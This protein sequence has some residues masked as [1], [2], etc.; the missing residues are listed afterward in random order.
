MAIVIA[1]F[2]LV[3][4][5][6]AWA[7]IAALSAHLAQ[8]QQ[9]LRQLEML[10]H[11]LAGARPARTQ[12]AAATDAAGLPPGAP[13]MPPPLPGMRGDA[14]MP[15]AAPVMPAPPARPP[16]TAVPVPPLPRQPEEPGVL[17]RLWQTGWGWL[18]HGNVPVKVGMLVL[19]AGV[20]ALLKYAGDQGWMRVP[21]ELRLLGIAAAA[22]GALV[23]AWN[24]RASKPVFSKVV[25]GG[26]IGVLLLTVF[27][28][29][30]MYGFMPLPLA[31]A[32]SVM[33]IAGL[34]ILALKQAARSLAVLGVLAGFMAPLWLSDGSG[35]HVFLFTYYALVN[36]GIFAIAWYRPWRELIALGFVFTWG[37]GLAWGMFAYRAE[38]YASTQPFLLLF[39]LMY[40]L[41]PFF[42]A[43]KPEA[44]GGQ[45]VESMLLF[46]TPLLAVLVQAMLLQ[47][48][49]PL[50]G[51]AV[52]AALMYLG[53]ALWARGK[54]A[55]AGIFT[56]HAML[57]AGFATL[58]VPLAFSAQVSS[59]VFAVEGVLLVAFGLRQGRLLP[60]LAGGLLQ[61]LAALAYIWMLGD[62]QYSAA[63]ETLLLNATFAHTLWL[64]LAGF[65]SAWLWQRRGVGVAASGAYA[66]GLLWWLG[67]F[68]SQ[69][70]HVAPLWT[71]LWWMGLLMLTVWLAAEASR[72]VPGVLLPG[73]S[74]V[75]FLGAVLVLFGE[76]LDG[77]NLFTKPL[78]H[79]LLWLLFAVATVRSLHG[80]RQSRLALP[81]Q[82][83]WVWTWPYVASGVLVDIQRHAGLGSGWRFA[84]YMLPWVAMLWLAWKRPRL[85]TWPV[86]HRA[87]ALARGLATS[88]LVVVGLLFAASLW[89]DGNPRPLPWLP[90]L[91][92]MELMQAAAL[93]LAAALLRERL[94]GRGVPVVW[95]WFGGGLLWL[96]LSML[97][98]RTVYHYGAVG[99]W[100]PAMLNTT[101]VQTSL[102]LAWSVLGM[103]GWIAGSRRGL[104]GVWMAGAILM[105]LALLKLI[106][107]DR[108]YLGNLLGIG[109]FIGYGLLCM[110]VGW[111]A[112]APP[113]AR[114][115]GG[116]HA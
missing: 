83:L 104:R 71:P 62:R 77:P 96:W 54:P 70:P 24:K 38:L 87:G 26:S 59:L 88:F 22:M 98:V 4:A 45:W 69:L 110:V 5:I 32:L 49:L 51:A 48:R 12:V 90:L 11:P 27:A 72:R 100:T 89:L 13:V 1:A 20:A 76:N 43:R 108:Q 34:V 15:P 33:L 68:I 111:F 37:V 53:G 39:F 25:Q 46:A 23:L 63:P 6:A 36:F 81:M 86:Q 55:F 93:L 52:M 99:E 19:L 102:T 31:F 82:A 16:Q 105:S 78:P 47:A 61:L 107:V 17:T 3:L 114:A 116:S 41:L 29:S 44:E 56:A 2:A 40:F 85:V 97:V 35:N 112:P 21:M 109:S 28:A 66:W 106:V 95:A 73:S 10:P 30:K 92:P 8:L 67:A 9:R 14:A 50:A 91:N 65:A 42:M 75:L 79:V 113:R 80:L 18:T 94:A 74:L 101:L 64:A 57:A 103:A 7:K 60:Q 84:L 115:E 58:A